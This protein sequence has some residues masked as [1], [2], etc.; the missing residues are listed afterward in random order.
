MTNSQLFKND[1]LLIFNSL[2]YF[3]KKRF[4]NSPCDTTAIFYDCY[5]T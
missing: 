4:K 3:L 5:K 2:P 1:V